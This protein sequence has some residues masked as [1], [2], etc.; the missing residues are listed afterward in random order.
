MNIDLTKEVERLVRA[1]I[2]DGEQSIRN[3]TDVHPHVLM[4]T[5]MQGVAI[6]IASQ[7]VQ[8]AAMQAKIDFLI[9]QTTGI[10]PIA[11]PFAPPAPPTSGT[12]Q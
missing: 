2:K 5:I 6:G 12:L 3:N 10:N 1:L 4:H 9:Q 8:F 7:Q 11:D